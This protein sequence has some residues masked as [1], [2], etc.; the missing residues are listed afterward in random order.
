MTR[1]T[2]TVRQCRLNILQEG[3]AI[4]VDF[5]AAYNDGHGRAPEASGPAQAV[6][7]NALKFTF[8]GSAISRGTRTIKR[9]GPEVILTIKTT[10]VAD[11]RCFVFYADNLRL[12][13]AAK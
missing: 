8:T 13:P 12:K 2:S 3:D 6:D 11:S 7:K 1:N 10:R 9:S 5:D 4:S